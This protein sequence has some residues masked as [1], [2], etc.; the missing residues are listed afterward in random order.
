[1]GRDTGPFSRPIARIWSTLQFAIGPVNDP[2]KP[3]EFGRQL[4]LSRWPSTIGGIFG[5]QSGNTN[6]GWAPSGDT[7]E[8]R[9]PT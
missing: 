9:P 3:L 7:L 4:A 1:M 6:Q 8:K 2:T 5:L